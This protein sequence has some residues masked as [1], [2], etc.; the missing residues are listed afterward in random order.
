M[1]R[2]KEVKFMTYT[3]P[4]LNGFA[5]IAAIQTSGPNAKTQGALELGQQLLRS[6]PAY[7]AD[8]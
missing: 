3:K 7:E 1:S 8:E 4:K 6:Q 2:Q 5:A